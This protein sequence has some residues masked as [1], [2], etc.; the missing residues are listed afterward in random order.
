MVFTHPFCQFHT[1]TLFC[2]HTQ[3]Y[4][5]SCSDPRKPEAIANAAAACCLAFVRFSSKLSVDLWQRHCSQDSG[6]FFC[7]VRPPL[8]SSQIKES[9]KAATSAT[10]IIKRQSEQEP[11]DSDWEEAATIRV[12]DNKNSQSDAIIT[13]FCYRSFITSWLPPVTK[14]GSPSFSS[15]SSKVFTFLRNICLKS[16]S[17]CWE[18]KVRPSHAHL[19]TTVYI[20]IWLD[21]CKHVNMR[22]NN[23][24]L[25]FLSLWR[26]CEAVTGRNPDQLPRTVLHKTTMKKLQV[27]WEKLAVITRYK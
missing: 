12:I 17:L 6:K 16:D 22:R 2:T 8:G 11:S 4:T 25:S 23:S 10:K 26:S 15:S 1:H 13:F 18:I 3:K 27:N 19:F 20:L 14:R 21:L 7:Y 9:L 5:H 24:N